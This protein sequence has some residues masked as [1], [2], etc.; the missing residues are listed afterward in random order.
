MFDSSLTNLR[1]VLDAQARVPVRSPF[2]DPRKPTIH[3]LRAVGK[4][5]ERPRRHYLFPLTQNGDGRRDGVDFIFAGLNR[6]T[7]RAVIRG[8]RRIK[9]ARGIP[10]RKR[11]H[12]E[13]IRAL[14]AVR[15]AARGEE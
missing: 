14:G 11:R 10:P 3:E 1:A 12:L 9:D 8:Q 2:A 5:A 15:K 13:R 6:A 7:M 4:P